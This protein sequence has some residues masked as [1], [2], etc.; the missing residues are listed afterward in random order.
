MTSLKFSRRFAL[1]L[2]VPLSAAVA[3]ALPSTALAASDPNP[4]SISN[5]TLSATTVT[6]GSTLHVGYDVDDPDGVRSV[7]PI[8]E[9]VVDSDDGDQGNSSRLAFRSTGDTTAGFDIP[10]SPSDQPCRYRIIG[11]GVTDSLG[12]V[13]DVY[14]AAYA[15]EKGL[16]SPTFATS[17]LV[18]EVTEGPANQNPPTVSSVSLSSREVATG[19]DFHISWSV[20]DPDGVRSVSPILQRGWEEKDD[21]CSVSSAYYHGGSSIDG[22]DLT[23]DSNRIGRH[24]L[25]G[26]SVTDDL[27]FETDVYESSY[28][29]ANGISGATFSVADPS[30]LCFEVTGSAIDRNP[31]TVSNVSISAKRVPVGVLLRIYCNVGDADG[32][33]SVSPILGDPGYV[34]DPNSVKARKTLSCSYDAARGYIEIEF[35]TSLSMGS[36]E[37]HALAVLDKAGHETFV[38]SS[39]YAERNGKTGVRTF[40]VDDAEDVTFDVTAPL[41]AATKGNGQAY[42]KGNED[43]LTFRF[44]GPLDEFTRLL[45]DGN[46]ASTENYTATKGST[47]IELKPAYLDTLAA[48]GHTVTAVWKDGTATDASFTVEGKAQG[49][50][51]G[52]TTDVDS[53]GDNK[54]DPATP[55]KDADEASTK[56]SGHTTTDEPKLAVTGDSAWMAS[57]ALAMAATACFAAARRL[58]PKQHRHEQ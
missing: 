30:E 20:A 41:Y 19:A 44:S 54:S 18:Y 39:A 57:I 4:P 56:R 13:T 10:T 3:L 23:F 43:G 53:P 5:V 45:V 8:V 14:D 52:G 34:E 16:N 12:W 49:E 15:E 25:I 47:I 2:L 36:F 48:G 9:V 32:V 35:P 31:P 21:G 11:L 28:A 6:A 17:P 40:D 37:I 33:K 58:E 46:E 26:L 7:T 51:A 1:S 42:A 24:R 38:Y 22:F 50:Q 29:R 27:G 55:E